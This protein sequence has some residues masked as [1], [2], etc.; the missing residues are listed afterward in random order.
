MCGLSARELMTYNHDPETDG[1]AVVSI[2]AA[3]FS[4]YGEIPMTS[5][6]ERIYKNLTAELGYGYIGLG[7]VDSARLVL[8]KMPLMDLVDSLNYYN[9][10]WSMF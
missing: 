8:A 9:L 2:V 4:K 7:K 5:A 1:R 10:D 3:V 6:E